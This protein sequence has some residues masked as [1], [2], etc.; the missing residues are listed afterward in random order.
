MI[1]AIVLAAGRSSRMGMPKMLLPWGSDTII[2]HVIGVLVQC[3]LSEIVVV[4]GG[5][6]ALVEARL[7]DKSVNTVFNPNFARGE[8]LSSVQVGLESLPLACTGALICLGDQPQ[9]Q[10]KVVQDLLNLA[11]AGGASL[12]APSYQNRRGHPWLVNRGY[13]P[14]IL[15]LQPPLTLR[16]FLRAH[17]GQISYLTVDTASVLMDV[18]TPDEYAQQRPA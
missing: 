5:N 8:M 16:D 10:P 3:G 15:A 6:N 7:R 9:I 11:G 14:E 13:W 17:T 1:G 12:V 4:T 2:E 18:D